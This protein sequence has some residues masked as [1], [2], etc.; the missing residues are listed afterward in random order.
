MIDVSF[1]TMVKECWTGVIDGSIFFKQRRQFRSSKTKKEHWSRFEE[2]FNWQRYSPGEYH[3]N[4]LTVTGVSPLHSIPSISR[5]ASARKRRMAI[6]DQNLI[7]PPWHF[8]PLTEHQTIF[9]LLHFNLTTSSLEILQPT[10]QP[11]TNQP[12]PWN[13]HNPN[14]PAP[15]PCQCKRS[16]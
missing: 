16:L 11:P 3:N 15:S 13:H 1:G 7:L 8:P 12:R 2:T 5:I 14:Q 9:N 10:N 4:G 6:E